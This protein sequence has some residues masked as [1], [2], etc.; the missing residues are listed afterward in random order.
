[1]H[2]RTTAWRVGNDQRLSHRV[3]HWRRLRLAQPVLDT[4]RQVLSEGSSW[5]LSILL[6]I[7]YQL[8]NKILPETRALSHNSKL[9]VELPHQTGTL[10]AHVMCSHGLPCCPRRG[11][12]A[13]C[14]SNARR[15]ALLWGGFAVGRAWK[16]SQLLTSFLLCVFLFLAI[17]RF[18]S[19]WLV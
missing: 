11:G 12:G 8:Q 5:G 6:L 9:K 17:A 10:D 14:C 13:H 16:C 18:N 15:M 1:M 7:N 4:L 19:M 2:V 3:D